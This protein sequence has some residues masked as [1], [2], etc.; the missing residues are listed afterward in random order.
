LTDELFL[1]FDG[2]LHGVDRIIVF[3]TLRNIEYLSFLQ[4]I[5]VYGTFE[6]CTVGFMRL[7]TIHG[8]VY[9]Y[10]VPLVYTL[11]SK[12]SSEYEVNV[13]N[14]F[15]KVK[16]LYIHFKCNYRF[17]KCTGEGFEVCIP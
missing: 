6:T 12:R 2:W 10:A 9:E 15:L 4:F 13:L 7:Y 3:N 17:W 5:L 14:I 11:L 16:A 1:L 8:I